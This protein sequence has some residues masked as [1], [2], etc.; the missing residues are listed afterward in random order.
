MH[1][2]TT[3]QKKYIKVCKS[4]FSEEQN[5]YLT[6]GSLVVSVFN[7]IILF[8]FIFHIRQEIFFTSKAQAYT[9]NFKQEFIGAC[10]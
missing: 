4:V 2:P 7:S 1:A 10:A 5:S 9:P 8:Y 6:N 3:P